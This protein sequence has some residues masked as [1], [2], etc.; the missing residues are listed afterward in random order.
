MLVADELTAEANAQFE[1]D[2]IAREDRRFRK[3]MECRYVGQGFELRADMPDGSLTRDNVKVV[4]DA[5]FDIHH[6]QYGHAFRDQVTEAVTLRVVA[7]A[8]VPALRLP[9]LETGGRSD[10]P[11]ARL[12][13]AKTIFDDGVGVDTPRY[14]RTK[15]LAE[16]T[17]SGPALVTQHNSTTL[18]PP[19]HTA[20]VLG[21]GDIRVVRH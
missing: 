3:V 10:P 9:R 7:N 12:R 16:D 1:A 15:L 18:V 21:H 6:Q 20:T 14:D 17:V 8:A 2:G 11:E 13:T 5:F 19:G 4:I